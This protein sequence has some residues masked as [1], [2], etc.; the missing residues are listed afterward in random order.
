VKTWVLDASAVLRLLDQQAGCERVAQIFSD[1][2]A[3]RLN[4]A[5][6]VLQWGEILGT[7]RKRRGI[8]DEQRIQQLLLEFPLQIESING[9]AAQRAAELKVDHG[10]GYADVFAL[11]L[12][13]RLPE[14]TLLTADY[15]FKAVAS[16]AR[17]EFLPAK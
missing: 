9:E 8:S 13:Q 11:E 14:A 10:L 2:M 6:C 12:A 4:L 15:G 17:I 3:K 7:I 16:L 5:I 1:S